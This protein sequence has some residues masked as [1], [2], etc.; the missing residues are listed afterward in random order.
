M[1]NPMPTKKSPYHLW[2]IPYLE[3][4]LVCSLRGAFLFPFFTACGKKGKSDHQIELIF[5]RNSFCLHFPYIWHDDMSLHTISCV[6]RHENL[7]DSVKSESF[8]G[9]QRPR[10]IQPRFLCYSQAPFEC[11]LVG[12]VY[13]HR[14][15][16]IQFHITRCP[17]LSHLT[18]DMIYIMVYDQVNDK[19]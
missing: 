10:F 16:C 4:R 9:E 13:L 19:I 18:L 15:I 11:F 17:S 6:L 7:A 2:K 5:R 14:A 12:E 3:K 1:T 8:I